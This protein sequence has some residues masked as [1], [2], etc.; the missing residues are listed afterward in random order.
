M[1]EDTETLRIIIL[2]DTHPEN[3]LERLQYLDRTAHRVF[4]DQTVTDLER[5]ITDEI[6][7]KAMK[8]RIDVRGEICVTF[9]QVCSK[10]PCSTCPF[11]EFILFIAF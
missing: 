11:I 9:Y 6:R 1:T 7:R 4:S 8:L 10:N 2:R 5:V 3:S